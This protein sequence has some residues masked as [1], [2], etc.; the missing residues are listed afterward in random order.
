MSINVNFID[1]ILKKLLEQQHKMPHT[2]FHVQP[3]LTY[4]ARKFFFSF[5]LQSLLVLWL[6]LL[7]NETVKNVFNFNL[8]FFFYCFYCYLIQGSDLCV[9]HFSSKHYKINKW[10]RKLF[11]KCKQLKIEMLL[12]VH[13]H[14]GNFLFYF[15]SHFSLIKCKFLSIFC[16]LFACQHFYLIS[17]ELCLTHTRIFI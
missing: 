11:S 16:L 5:L 1:P 8:I 12:H 14:F 6:L 17:F 15:F 3:C 13:Y 2:C 4:N 9:V 7:T 10:K